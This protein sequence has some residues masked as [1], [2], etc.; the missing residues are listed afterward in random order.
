MY[1][2][3]IADDE[4]IIRES[5][6]ELIDWEALDIQITACCKN[7]LEALD[8]IMDTAPDIVMTDI[9]M[10]GI[11]GLEL[12]G[13][14]RSLDPRIQFIIL[15]GHPEFD[16][17]R[18][19]LQYGVREYLLKPISEEAII[20]A[21]K[22]AAAAL[23]EYASPAIGRLMIQ[24]LDAHAS[25]DREQARHLLSNFLAHSIRL[26]ELRHLG[27]ALFMELHTR[28]GPL[29]H[30]DMSQFTG[31][32]LSEPD[33]DSLRAIIIDQT[34]SLLFAEEEGSALTSPAK[35]G[36]GKD[37]I[38]D[39]VKSYV[40]SHLDDENLSLKYI[41]ENLLYINVNYLSRAFTKQSGE[42]FS[43]Y[44][45]RTRIEKA[46][47]MLCRNTQENIHAIAEA[48]GF[49]GNPQYFSQVFKKYAGMTPS[50]FVEEAGNAG[51]EL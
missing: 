40:S 33:M 32:I 15:T 25:D 38:A 48:V 10:P 42:K 51:G 11:D 21:V 37:S 30:E 26:E 45:N 2:L 41:A 16:Y 22:N 27:I 7:G 43:N 50:Q 12:I 6:S 44:L 17:A 3:L 35:N 36:R 29:N 28:F 49:G 31:R 1:K 24:L 23:P 14:I 39:A 18:R 8:A 5:V 47:N 46:K 9:R 20:D 4:K 19:A 13:K 34:V